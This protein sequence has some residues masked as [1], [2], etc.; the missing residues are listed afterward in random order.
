MSA[1]VSLG[2]FVPGGPVEIATHP[3]EIPLLY[4][5]AG[6]GHELRTPGGQLVAAIPADVLLTR[7]SCTTLA[8]AW[9]RKGAA[10]DW[11]ETV[12]TLRRDEP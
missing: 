1:P 4:V 11:R 9:L 7:A 10:L 12:R 3:V 2:A 8:A 6:P 5:P